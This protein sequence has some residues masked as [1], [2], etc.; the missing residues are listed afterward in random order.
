MEPM[1][2]SHPRT[3]CMP[4]FIVA[5]YY[6]PIS[7]AQSCH[8]LSPVTWGIHSG[9]FYM[10]NEP[11]LCWGCSCSLVCMHPEACH[12][13]LH[14]LKKDRSA[15][16]AIYIPRFCLHFQS[17]L[18][19]CQ[20]WFVKHEQSWGEKSN[21]SSHLVFLL[22]CC[23]AAS[24]LLFPRPCL[25]LSSQPQTP[26]L[27]HPP[28]LT[29]LLLVLCVRDAQLWKRTDFPV[30]TIS[31]A[32]EPLPLFNV[33]RC[34]DLGMSVQLPELSDTKFPRAQF[35]ELNDTKFPWSRTV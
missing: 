7:L 32:Q 26:F 25:I 34:Q 1:C 27:S 35:P 2:S 30:A 5:L 17:S 14:S 12:L 15:K 6:L 33:S 3:G 20:Y 4:L 28:Q 9:V 16:P 22:T 11:A 8:L 23:G 19:K 29:Y 13:H 24:L 10:L 31:P 21:Y 18:F